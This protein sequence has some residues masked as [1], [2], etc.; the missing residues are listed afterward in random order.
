MQ[1]TVMKNNTRVTQSGG[2]HI[3]E[4]RRLPNGV[5]VHKYNIAGYA[6]YEKSPIVYSA[7]E[8]TTLMQHHS[9]PSGFAHSTTTT[10]DGVPGWV[11]EV[12]TRCLSPELDALPSFS[13]ERSNAVRA[14][15][16]TNK[17]QEQQWIQEAFKEDF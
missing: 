5:V 2:L 3:S 7:W 6:D 13:I 4:Y 14:Y 9:L 11:G 12:S 15:H 16:E 10:I 17:E 8:P 1:V